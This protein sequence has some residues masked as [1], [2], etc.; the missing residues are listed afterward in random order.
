MCYLFKQR[1]S[2]FLLFSF[3]SVSYM[4]CYLIFTARSWHVLAWPRLGYVISRTKIFSLRF[5][6]EK[7]TQ[8][9]CYH[10]T[11]P[12]R[13]VNPFSVGKL[14]W[15]P[16]AWRNYLS[17]R[18]FIP[19]NTLIAVNCY[20]V[21]HEVLAQQGLKTRPEFER[22]LMLSQWPALQSAT[23]HAGRSACFF[24]PLSRSVGNEHIFRLKILNNNV[25]QSVGM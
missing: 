25:R 3:F 9:S 12:V 16:R 18:T 10:E 17:K 5:P 7:I 23:C 14:F 24:I 13:A 15:D 1:R 4:F 6:P 19:G 22:P 11:I 2:L 21:M 20:Y 8:T